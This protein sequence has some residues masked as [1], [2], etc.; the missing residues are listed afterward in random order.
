[1][2]GLPQA[3]IIDLVNIQPSINPSQTYNAKVLLKKLQAAYFGQTE[4][5]RPRIRKPNPK[6]R[7]NNCC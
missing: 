2:N 1:M 3:S 4:D 7:K 6:N 5:Q